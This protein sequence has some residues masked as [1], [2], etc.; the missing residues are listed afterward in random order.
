MTVV[1]I[2]KYNSVFKRYLLLF[3]EQDTPLFPGAI[4]KMSLNLEAYR[5][6][7]EPEGHSFDLSPPSLGYGL[8]E[9]QTAKG[10]D[11]LRRWEI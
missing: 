2:K 8:R 6:G 7:R 9:I 11:A 3:P 5:I 1:R 10:D 4:K